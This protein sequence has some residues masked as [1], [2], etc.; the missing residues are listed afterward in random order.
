MSTAESTNVE[1]SSARTRSPAQ[2]RDLRVGVDVGG[3]NTD[4]VVIDAAG[5]VLAAVKVATTPEPIDG[6]RTALDE[7]LVGL[8]HSC[9]S[10]AMLG[11]THS[12]NA[13]IQRRGLDRVAVLRLAAPSSLGLRPGAAWPDDIHAEVVGATA[14]IEGGHEYNGREI[15]PLDTEAV[16]RLAAEAIRSECRSV[17]VAGAFSPATGEHEIRA[18]DILQAELGADFPI[19]LS[20]EIGSLGLL[21]RE[22]ATILN[23]ALLSVA[24]RVISGF[25]EALAERQL[26]VAAYLTQNDG[27]LIVAGEAGRYPVLTLGSG[28]TNSMRGAC[29]LAE[30]NDAIVIDVGGTSADAGILVGGFPRQSSAAVEVG[31][32]RTNFRMPDLISM[33]LGGGTIVRNGAGGLR[34]GPDSVGYAVA[35]EAICVGG[36]VLTLSDVSLAAGRMTGFGEPV[37]VQELDRAVVDGALAWVD[38]QISIMSDRMKSTRAELPLLAVGGGAHLIPDAI[39]GVSKVIRPRHQSVANAYGAGIAEASGSVDRVYSYDTSS[40]ED[41]LA[42]V[43]ELAANAAVRAG[44][45]PDRVRITTVTEVPVT[46]VPGGRCR[47]MVKAAGPLA[48][49]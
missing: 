10:K 18:R 8:D 35:T 17:A 36:S 49:A 26:D 16:R 3:T 2:H 39:P 34:I 45:D 33:G 7:V 1:S 23:A 47:V 19:S 29:A 31:G 48:S 42:D 4:A 6:I 27:T 32:V 24:S 37:R 20:H 21:E 13:I 12:A 5:E 11:T 38:E 28:P 46:Y 40:R 25:E 9:V 44:A 15:A 30:V 14:I 43:R 41:C 22:N